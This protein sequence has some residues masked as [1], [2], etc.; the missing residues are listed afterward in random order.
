MS[1]RE[2][3]QHEY[4]AEYKPGIASKRDKFRPNLLQNKSPINTHNLF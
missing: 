2:L 1:V 3:L 4:T